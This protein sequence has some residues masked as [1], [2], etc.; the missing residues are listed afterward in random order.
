MLLGAGGMALPDSGH[1]HLQLCQRRAACPAHPWPGPRPDLRP[2]HQHRHGWRCPRGLRRCLRSGQHD[3]AGRRVDRDVG[4]QHDRAQR[5]GHLPDR[6]TTPA[7]WPRRSRPPTA[8][9]SPSAYRR[10]CSGSASSSRSS[11]CHLGAGSPT[12]GTPVPQPRPYPARSPLPPSRA[13]AVPVQ[14]HAAEAIPVALCSCS[15]VI[16]HQVTA[17]TG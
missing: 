1:R 7:R 9:R 8:T 5:H 14:V 16:T 3:A 6:R 13:T 4:A 17:S 10:D 15:P 12:S 11:C 2:G